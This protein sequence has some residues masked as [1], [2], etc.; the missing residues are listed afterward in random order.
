MLGIVLREPLNSFLHAGSE[1]RVV[2]P[3]QA[4]ELGVVRR[5]AVD[6]R[7]FRDIELDAAPV[8]LQQ[9]GDQERRVL[10]R[11]LLSGADV[12]ELDVVVMIQAPHEGARQVLGIGVFAQRRAVAP[13]GDLRI[14]VL[15]LVEAPDERRHHDALAL[16]EIHVRAED[17]IH[18]QADRLQA[19][20]GP[21]G[22]DAGIDQALG[23]GVAVIG[24]MRVAHVNALLADWVGGIRGI[25]PGG[26]SEGDLADA[27]QPRGLEQ[28]EV[29][30]HVVP[31]ERGGI[32]RAVGDAAAQSGKVQDG[33]R[34]VPGHASER[35]VEAR[36]IAVLGTEK[37]EFAIRIFFR[38]ISHACA[39]KPG[40]PCN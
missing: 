34:L 24:F 36:E 38:N 13:D 31:Q 7:G 19:V 9:V 21:V 10:D 23:E 12:E 30:E 40:T 32:L 5:L 17:A 26:K 2:E 15:V 28:V 27:K 39:K 29:H 20:F 22:A 35:C 1:R 4:R 18:R 14:I 16:A 11:V 33:V 25:H 8:D 37:N 6:A 3:G